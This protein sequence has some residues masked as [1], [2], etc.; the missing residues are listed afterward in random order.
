MEG[1]MKQSEVIHGIRAISAVRLLVL[2]ASILALDG[3]SKQSEPE[4]VKVHAHIHVSQNQRTGDLLWEFSIPLKEYRA[5]IDGEPNADT[6]AFSGQC[7][8]QRKVSN[9][10]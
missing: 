7:A 10:I 5:L 2:L 1:T 3:C 8:S 4:A 9:T 6:I